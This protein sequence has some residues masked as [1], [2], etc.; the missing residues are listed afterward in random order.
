MKTCVN[1]EAS[2]CCKEMA[3]TLQLKVCQACKKAM[4]RDDWNCT[5]CKDCADKLNECGHCRGK[6]VE[7]KQ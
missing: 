2:G 1:D 3:H 5:L 7:N 4:N 6:L